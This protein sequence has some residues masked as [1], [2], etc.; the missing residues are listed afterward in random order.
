MDVR[1]AGSIYNAYD[2]HDVCVNELKQ[3]ITRYGVN[4]FQRY[5][6]GPFF[7]TVDDGVYIHYITDA[8]GFYPVFF[9]HKHA[10]AQTTLP[11][12][13]VINKSY[14]V[15]SKTYEANLNPYVPPIDPSMSCLKD[16]IVLQNNT[17][18]SVCKADKSISVAKYEPVVCREDGARLYSDALKYRLSKSKKPAFSLTTGYDTRSAVSVANCMG[19]DITVYTY[20]KECDD[21]KKYILPFLKNATYL[22]MYDT[23]TQQMHD[24]YYSRYLKTMSGMSNVKGKLHVFVAY[25]RVL[26]TG[27]DLCIECSGSNQMLCTKLSKMDDSVYRI[28][29]NGIGHHVKYLVDKGIYF[30]P[31]LQKRIIFGVDHGKRERRALLRTILENNDEPLLTTMLFSHK[32][33]FPTKTFDVTKNDCDT[34]QHKIVYDPSIGDRQQYVL[35]YHKVMHNMEE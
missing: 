6:E 4:G 35:D 10:I 32:H 27:H 28:F 21:V 20:G 8:F 2:F 34:L 3:L 11:G 30:N 5:V 9:S 23:F 1:I 18:V 19:K 16:W 31:I 14:L 13:S 22:D 7:V 33:A 26:E 17:I 12:G 29:Y 15:L 25:D 24:K